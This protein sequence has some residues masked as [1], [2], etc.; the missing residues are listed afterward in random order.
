MSRHMRAHSGDIE[1]LLNDVLD[2]PTEDALRLYGIDIN[3]D[4]SCFDTLL[5]KTFGS[6]REWAQYSREQED[7]EYEE[8]INQYKDDARPI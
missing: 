7:I 4:G 5:N 3:A 2:M 1:H 8:D 6:L